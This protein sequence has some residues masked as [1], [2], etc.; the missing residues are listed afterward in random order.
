VWAN[1]PAENNPEVF[2]RLASNMGLSP[3]LD[4]FD[5]LDVNDRELLAFIPRPVHAIIFLC[6]ADVYHA[7][8]DEIEEQM[9]EYQGCG[10]AEPVMWFKQTIGHS[11]GLMAFLHSLMNGA[12]RSCIPPGSQ[13]DRIRQ[14]SIP[15]LPEARADLLYESDF[16]EMAHMNAA[17]MGDSA[18]PLPEDPNYF[19]FMAFVKAD[20]GHLWELNGGLPG[21]LD[22]GLLEPDEDALSPRALDRTVRQFISGRV[23]DIRHSIV[24]LGPA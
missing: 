16:L 3:R 11:C 4:F 10:S 5:V 15:L 9:E 18:A 22:H 6:P 19:H 23:P 2:R 7:T 17:D 12:G 14:S 1:I 21:P 8:R 13:L 24:A 20:D